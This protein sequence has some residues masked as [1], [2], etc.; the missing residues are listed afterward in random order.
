MRSTARIALQV[1]GA[2]F[3]VL[4]ILF[5]LGAWRLS[6]G[7]L[8]LSF[9]SPYMQEALEGDDLPYRFEFQNTVLVWSGWGEALE[10]RLTDLRVADTNGNTL[11]AVP[12]ASLGLSG[13]SLLRG[14][15]APTSIELIEPHLSLVRGP[16]GSVHL[17]ESGEGVSADDA[18]GD[19]LI[20]D[21]LDPPRADH[22]LSQLKRVSLRDAALVLRDRVADL[23]WT[24]PSADLTLNLDD[25]A[26]LGH[27]SMELQVQDLET[28][29]EVELFHHRKSKMGSA[30]VGFAGLNLAELAFVA[31]EVEDFAGLR[32]PLSGTLAFDIAPGGILGG[33]AFDIEGGQGEVAISGV[34]PAPVPIRRLA[35][36]GSIDGGLSRLTLE[37]FEVDTDR[38]QFALDGE[39]WRTDSGIG[40]KGRFQATD[41]PFDSLGTYWPETFIENG[42]EWIV[43]NIADGVITHLD[44]VLDI[45]PGD[46]ENE[47]FSASSAVGTLAFAEAS[48]HYLRSMPP[49][50]GVEGRAHFT[51][52]RL[53]ITMS[54][55]RVAGI[56]A[57]HGKVLLSEIHSALPRMAVTVEAEGPVTDALAL[58]DHPPLGLVSESDLQLSQAGGTVHTLFA[59]D[60]PLLKTVEAWQIDMTAVARIRDARLEEIAGVVD[61]TKGTLRLGV[62]NASMDLRGTA[63]LEGMPATVAWQ[64]HFGDE[65]PFARRFD[66]ATTVTLEGQTALGLDLAPY[67]QGSLVVDGEYTDPGGGGWPRATLALDATLA[68][69]EIPELHWIKPSGSRGAV[70]VLASLPAEGAVELTEVEIET[71]TLYGL[72]QVTLARGAGG[73]RA[74]TIEELR[75]GATDI[76]GKIETGDDT[77]DVSLWGAS[78]DARPYLSRLT[79]EGAPQ[80]GRLVLDLDVDRLLT[81]EDQ[82][83]TNFRA[84]F[85]V[86]SESRHAGFM[87][88]TLATGVPMRV[89]LEPHEGKRLVTVRSRDAG[90]VARTFGV[91]DNALGGDLLL[92]AAVHDDRPGVPITGTVRIEDYRVVNAPTLA[93]LLSIATLTGFLDELRGEE[94]I[95]FSRFEMPFSV[96]EDILTIRDGRASGF[97]LGVNAEGTVD[98][99]TDRV[100]LS[101]TLVP[102][103]TLNTIFDA[104]PI[105]GD[106]L[107]GGEGEGLFAASFRVGGTT[108]E[109]DISVNPLSVL[110]PGFLRDLFPFLGEGEAT[111]SE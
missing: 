6:S 102:A 15:I 42:R 96:D 5:A 87:E 10:I 105:L 45:E 61:M 12:A 88:G 8:S 104:I 75:L 76:A 38:P 107:T 18:A 108:A 55:G 24:T 100:D 33:V 80:F 68:R 67:V 109:P 66:A 2:L 99:E 83:L 62:D 57:S 26:I 19:A 74:I 89:S 97:A 111:D 11:A 14:T 22:P 86:D 110:A 13:A 16:D 81:T 65:A 44:A 23:T 63:Q 9:L 27:L 91:Y 34:F 37:S 106:L 46:V 69:L 73:V 43:Q 60:L 35:A 7:P 58:L 103:Y 17:A 72:G 48:I 101:G 59:L 64:E 52:D 53:D 32:V 79:T 92:E 36:A 71:D 50:S 41:L 3:A 90:A 54:G 84:H 21:L 4:A 30:A 51:G 1:F 98:L 77:T 40:I 31:P 47:R 85:E 49:V 39:F 95:A 56:D 28:H 29:L 94:G 82:Q 20:A 70:R 93:K 25:D 78:L